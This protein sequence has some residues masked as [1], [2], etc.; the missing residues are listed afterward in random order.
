MLFLIATST[1]IIRNKNIKKKELEIFLNEE[2]K[3]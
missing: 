3:I 1:Y 2:I